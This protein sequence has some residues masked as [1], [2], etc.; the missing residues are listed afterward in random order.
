MYVVSRL[1]LWL[2]RLRWRAVTYSAL[3]PSGPRPPVSGCGGDIELDPGGNV[4]R[5]TSPNW[6]ENYPD[7]LVCEWTV[8]T[9]PGSRVKMKINSLL[10]ESSFYGCPYDKYKP[11]KS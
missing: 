3:M 1:I 2:I 8:R 7:N 10:L 9:A 11:C 6:P 4:T 5:L